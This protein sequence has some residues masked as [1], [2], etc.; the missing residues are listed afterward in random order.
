MG[1]HPLHGSKKQSLAF[2]AKACH[3]PITAQ[4][5]IGA[6]RPSK[7]GANALVGCCHD[8][9][10]INLLLRSKEKQTN[11]KSKLFINRNSLVGNKLLKGNYIMSN[12]FS[13]RWRNVPS[14]P[15]V[16]MAGKLWEFYSEWV[17]I[18]SKLEGVSTSRDPGWQQK[19]QAVGQALD[20]YIDHCKA[21][22][23]WTVYREM[24]K[25]FLKKN[26]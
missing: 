13:G 5:H 12:D 22:N 10:F 7:S 19:P 3:L 11:L 23:R 17:D 8:N 26:R 21:Q 2:P 15:L 14:F 1:G 24:G 25:F 9:L 16:R 20:M 18:G 6:S 4:R